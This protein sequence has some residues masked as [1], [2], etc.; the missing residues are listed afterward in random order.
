M[1]TTALTPTTLVVNAAVA[2]PSASTSTAG[3]GNGFVIANATPEQTVFR[4]TGTNAG[5]AV[6][7]AGGYTGS[8]PGA[9]ASGQGDFTVAVGA[10]NTV[11]IGP[12][13]SARFQQRDGSLILETSAVMAVQAFKV[14]R[15]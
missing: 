5:N 7:K 12:F 15:H 2:E 3:A 13:E 9:I 14:N 1:A 11:E 4:I 8:D 10:G 6:V